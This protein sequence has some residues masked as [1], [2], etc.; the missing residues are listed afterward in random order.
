MPDLVG[1]LLLFVV[2]GV[3]FIFIHLI[4]GK[5]IR[6]ARPDPEKLTIYECGEP[7][8]GTAWVQFDLRFYVVALLF[9]IFDVEVAFFFPWAVVFGKA[10]TLANPQTSAEERAAILAGTAEDQARYGQPLLPPYSGTEEQ[11]AKVRADMAGPADSE[12]VQ[13]TRAAASRFG[14]IAF[15]DILVFFGVLLV[16]FA[17]LWSRGDLE[18]VRSTAAERQAAL[19]KESLSETPTTE[20]LVGAGGSH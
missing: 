10:N 2:V 9:V 18:W 7:T 15:F 17:Y 11:R 16:G 14:W 5:L 8:I 19:G 1:Y 6:P 20:V 12:A 4:V 3:G 13:R